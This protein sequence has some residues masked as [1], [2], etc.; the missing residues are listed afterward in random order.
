LAVGAFLYDAIIT[1]NNIDN[2]GSV[3]I[4]TRNGAQWSQQTRLQAANP[5]INSNFGASVSLSTNGDLLAAGAPGETSGAGAAYLFTRNSGTWVQTNRLVAAFSDPDDEFGRSVSLS[6]E[7][8]TLAVGAS[9]EDGNSTDINRDQDNNA[10]ENSGAVFVYSQSA[11]NWAEIAYI[12]PRDSEADY[13]FGAR[14]S[15]ASDGALAIGAA[16][17]DNLTG[18][19]YLY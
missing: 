9:L 5:T 15:L 3:Y 13:Q 19:A 8:Q 7:G 12:K 18:K 4:F 1:P 10:E 6:P 11:G 2:I 16:G 17:K 14:V